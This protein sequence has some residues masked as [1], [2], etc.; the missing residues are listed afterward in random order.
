MAERLALCILPGT[1]W[2]AR[3][4][5]RSHARLR[6]PGSDAIFDVEFGNDALATADSRRSYQEYTDA[7]HEH[8]DARRATPSGAG[9]CADATVSCL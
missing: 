8:L 6:K 7:E 5:R 4:S 1:S 9:C 3:R 2:S